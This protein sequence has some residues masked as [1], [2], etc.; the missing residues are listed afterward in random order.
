MSSNALSEWLPQSSV[1]A[2]GM[3][4]LITAGGTREYIDPVRYISNAS[5]G[6][7]GFALAVAALKAGH[8]V[9]VITAPTN[10]LS[11]PKV[12]LVKVVS[13]DEM[14]TAVRKHFPKC[15]CLIM[16]AAV[17]DYKP[18]EKRKT[19]IK[20]NREPVL[21]EL[22]P[23]TDILYWAGR[24]KKKQQILA[25]FALEDKALKSRAEKKLKQKNLDLI[26]ANPVETIGSQS[27]S[28]H[29]KIA[30]G[31]WQTLPAAEKSVVALKIIS[32]IE[33]I[34]RSRVNSH[35]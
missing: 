23:T 11:A 18:A 29:L 20:K 24:N 22:L 6:K 4:V 12:N 5:S 26:I 15:D 30:T 31:K 17:C 8:K 19:K 34:A 16:A 14:F 35:N 13:A 33:Q 9:T 28:V 2:E 27:A 1:K 7:M 21:L 32:V 25:G 10:L 3:H